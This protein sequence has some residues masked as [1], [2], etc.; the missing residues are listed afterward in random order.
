MTGFYELRFAKSFD[1]ELRKI[2]RKLI[3]LI[4][5][6]ILDLEKNPRSLHTK[7]L[8]GSENEYRLRIGNYRVFY[9]I[10]DKTKVVAIFHI[11]HRKEAY[12]QRNT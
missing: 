4:V 1:R 6:K 8:K 9:T 7:K 2:D 12:R 10:D 11:A 3:P 5:E